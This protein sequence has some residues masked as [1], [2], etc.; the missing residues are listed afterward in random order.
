MGRLAKTDA[1]DAEV[2]ARFGSALRPEPR[3]LPDAQEQHLRALMT[4]KLIDIRTA[5]SNR[6][7]RAAAAVRQ[8]IK[9]IDKEIEDIDREIEKLIRKVRSGRKRGYSG[10]FPA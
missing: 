10:K 8:R 7:A 9:H 4:R 3:T 6:L 1:I 5:E 2:I